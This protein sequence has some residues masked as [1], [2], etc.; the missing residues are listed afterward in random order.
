MDVFPQLRNDVGV[1]EAGSG[2]RV[3]SSVALDVDQFAVYDMHN[4]KEATID[5]YGSQIIPALNT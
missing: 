1:G 2:R 3:V 5:A 4:A